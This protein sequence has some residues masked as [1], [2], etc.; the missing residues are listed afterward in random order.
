MKKYN[1]NLYNDDTLQNY[2][3]TINASSEKSAINKAEKMALNE[4]PYTEWTGVDTEEVNPE[5][6]AVYTI[7]SVLSI[8]IIS[9][10]YGIDDT[11][12]SVF[13]SDSGYKAKRTTKL[14]YDINGNAYIIR[15]KTKYY[16]NDFIKTDF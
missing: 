5:I 2:E 16:L 6:I 4:F 9:V 1:V 8:G 10:N 7:C 14:Y 3:V 13:I 12:T 15:Y 11:I